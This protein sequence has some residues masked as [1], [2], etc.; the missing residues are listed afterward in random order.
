AGVHILVATPGRLIDLIYNGHISLSGVR[1]MILDEADEM[2]KLGFLEDINLIF[3]FLIHEHQTLLFS[4]TMPLEVK[5]LTQSYLKDPVTIELNLEQRAP[6]SLE[7]HFK[8]I[9]HSD[10]L[11]ALLDYM[12]TESISQA[13]V[14][15]NT[16]SKSERLYNKLKG[17]VKSV[18][19]IHGGLEQS[20]R[21]SIIRR[22]KSHRIDIMIATDLAGRGLDF[23][24]V[25]H[26]IIFDFPQTTDIYTHRTGRAGRMGRLGTAVTFVSDRELRDLKRLL[27]VNRIVPVWLGEKPELT[28]TRGGTHQR[29]SRPRSR[30][31]RPPSRRSG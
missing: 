2:L 30:G 16:R 22:F 8:Y 24:K 17:H 3:S 28:Q 20:K 18:E 29:G 19:I 31:R 11:Q 15:C 1:T 21:T 7:H 4:A 10:R 13:I 12:Q 9:G 14:F 6:Q 26:V 5:K 23:M 25:S 27:E